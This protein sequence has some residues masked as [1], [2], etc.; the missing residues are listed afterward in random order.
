MDSTQNGAVYVA[1]I[2]REEYPLFVAGMPPDP[3]LPP[4]YDE[5]MRK[6]LLRHAAGQ[7]AG[8]DSVPVHVTWDELRLHAWR[9]KRQPTYDLLT[10]YAIHKGHR[11]AR[12]HGA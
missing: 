5:W 1:H 4:T 9:V 3:H 6:A 11:T 2:S 12:R 7:A 10:V 8:R